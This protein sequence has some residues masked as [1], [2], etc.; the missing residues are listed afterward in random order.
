MRNIRVVLI[1]LM[2]A[3]I[4]NSCYYHYYIPY[5]KKQKMDSDSICMIKNKD[6]NIF[7]VTNTAPKPDSNIDHQ[8][9]GQYLDISKIDFINSFVYFSD[10]VDFLIKKMKF[11]ISVKKENKIYELSDGK[12]NF[13]IQ[14]KDSLFFSKYFN[15]KDSIYNI[16]VSSRPKWFHYLINIMIDS[17]MIA[18]CDTF[19]FKYDFLL[20]I[21]SVDYKVSKTDT[22]TRFD[23]MITKSKISTH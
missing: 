21:N 22:L 7:Y 3:L 23:K 2:I 8:V 5:L 19:Y 13:D 9:K 20:N 16:H 4:T 11:D 10:S 15:L 18:L 17:D 1:L 12:I 14:Y 6:I